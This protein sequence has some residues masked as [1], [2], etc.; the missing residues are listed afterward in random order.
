MKVDFLNQYK[1]PYLQTAQGK[2]VFLAGVLLGY[3]ALK[4]VEGKQSDIG[5]APL[6]KQIQFGRLNFK[7][8]KRHLARVPQLLAAYR[9][10]IGDSYA[11]LTR[12]LAYCTDQIAL[13][14]SEELG[15]D[16]NFA[17]TVGF[18]NANDFYWKIFGRKERNQSSDGKESAGKGPAEG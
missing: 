12:L 16:G 11:S 15:T 7:T 3:L 18:T 1:D 6:F 4:Q 5:K 13:G 9:E 2:G 10:N 14:D 17:F 8:L